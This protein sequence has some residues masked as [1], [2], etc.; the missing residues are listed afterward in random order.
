MTTSRTDRS[1]RRARAVAGL[2]AW[3]AA[4]VAGVLLLP[5]VGGA[6]LA[7]PPLSP[8][9][10][11]AWLDGRDAVVAAFA[12]LRVVAVALAWYLLVTTAV[13]AVL[14]ALRADV[15]AGLVG[16]MTVPLA[17]DLAR[18]AVGAGLVV[19]SFSVTPIAAW[20]AVTPAR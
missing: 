18:R 8:D 7:G 13:V 17:R 5:D 1:S 6:D 11:A 12:L 10:W 3:C 14:S 15:L 19:S 2:V 4:L 20:G 16:R 9:G